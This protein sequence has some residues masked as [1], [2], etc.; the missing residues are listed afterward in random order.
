MPDTA[1]SE[2]HEPTSLRGIANKAKADKQHRFRDL[3][4][5]LDAFV[6][7]LRLDDERE[8]VFAQDP[9]WTVPE[10]GLGA[11]GPAHEPKAGGAARA[12]ERGWAAHRGPLWGRNP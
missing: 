10:I 1:G 8:L 5:C 7:D 6:G 9:S 2:H 12:E 4:R 11:T 3:Y